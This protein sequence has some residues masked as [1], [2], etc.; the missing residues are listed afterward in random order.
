M[1]VSAGVVGT[2]RAETHGN[3]PAVFSR[4]RS[5]EFTA[6]DVVSTQSARQYK[7]ATDL[8]VA[9]VDCRNHKE[10]GDLSGTLCSK[11]GYSLNY[12]NPVRQ[13]QAVRRLTPVEC[14]RLQGFEDGWTAIGHNGKPITD[15]KRY[16]AL[17][18]SV[19]LPCVDYILRGIVAANDN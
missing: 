11:Q 12:Q 5:D 7:D 10:L 18:N 3:V 19:A 4:Q 2:L 13:G 15:S 16:A 9:A 1:D 17:G 8:I 14:E 6:N